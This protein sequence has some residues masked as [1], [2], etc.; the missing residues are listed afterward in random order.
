M[1][2][3]RKLRKI[4][5]EKSELLLSLLNEFFGKSVTI[6]LAETALCAE[7]TVR[8]GADSRELAE[9]ALSSGVRVIPMGDERGSARLRLSFA[10]IA[11]DEMRPGVETLYSAVSP[12]FR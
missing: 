9:T 4:Y 12:Y 11:E 1:H 2:R 7:L 10:G 6:R 8:C 3:L 5:S